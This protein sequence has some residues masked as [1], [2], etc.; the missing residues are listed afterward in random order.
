MTIKIGISACVVGNKVRFDASNKPSNFCIKEL[1]Q[2]VEYKTFCPEVAIGMGV[3]RPSIRQVMPDDAITE[4]IEIRYSKQEGDVT[5]KM[6]DYSQET[7]GKMSEL[8]G[9]I[10]CAKSP[11]CGMER[12]KIY[13]DKGHTISH[14]GIGVFAEQVMKQNPNLPCEENGRLNDP[15]LRENFV[16]RVFVYRQW[17]DLIKSGVTV[18]KLCDFHAEKKY[19]LMSHKYQAY[20][21]LGRK[22]GE[23]HHRIEAFADEYI[24][25]LMAGLKNLANKKSH[26]NTLMHLQGYFKKYLNPTEKQELTESIDDYRRGLIPLYAPL[27]LIKHHLRNHPMQYLEQQTYLNPYP[28]ELRLRYG[29]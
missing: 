17:Q 13:S 26:A 2:Y 21:D 11:S 16:L 25:D 12:V 5:D 27:T 3:P 24:T 19:L 10:F 29:L 28:D 7:A 23:N 4:R 8:T 18:Q 22:L 9:F 14:K 20:K 15:L 6:H 1:G